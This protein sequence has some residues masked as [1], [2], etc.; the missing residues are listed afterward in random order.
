[1]NLGTLCYVIGFL[2]AAAAVFAFTFGLSI[3]QDPKTILIVLM[4]MCL[5]PLVSGITLGSPRT[6]K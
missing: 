6:A 3:G 5:A 2:I 4:L 1:M